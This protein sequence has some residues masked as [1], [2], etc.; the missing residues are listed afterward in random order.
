MGRAHSQAR[1][2]DRQGDEAGRH[3]CCQGERVPVQEQWLVPDP[4]KRGRI[5]KAWLKHMHGLGY[6][7]EGKVL[8][9]ADYGIPTIWKRYFGIAQADGRP[10][11]WPERTHAPRHL[12]KQLG[13]KPW[14]G[15]HTIIDWSLP[16]KSIF[17]RRKPLADATLRRTAK[18][19]MRYVVNAAR[20][21][22]VPITH[23]GA[24]RV[25]SLDEPL[26]TLTTA[27]RGELSV[28]APSLQAYYGGEQGLRRG[29]DPQ[30]PL[31]TFVTEPR[32]AL[33]TAHLQRDFGNSIGANLDEPAPT[34][35]PGGGG[36]SA[37]VAAF[38]AQHNSGEPGRPADL[39]LSTIVS[40]GSTQGVVTASMMALR[41]TNRHGRDIQEPVA[42]VTAGG[43]HAGVMAADLG[44]DAN[45][46]AHLILGFLQ[47]Y[48]SNGKQD[49]DIAAPLGALTQKARHGLVTATVGR[50]TF[51]INDIGMRMLE[52]EEGAAAHGF[53]RGSLP[54]K[55][56]IDGVERKLTKTEKYHLVGNSVP[57][58]MIRLL[59]ACN[60]RQE[61]AEAAE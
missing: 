56:T 11:V 48:Y 12:A 31:Q 38:M 15:A 35:T 4:K 37:L 45:D 24:D 25:H 53:A 52:P 39:P 8:V 22:I 36:K 6:S 3:R 41:G 9:C 7:F 14:V 5:W 61:F 30:E 21:F 20:P 40:K 29:G 27:H 44:E 42:T 49:D 2:C 19:V 26:R 57:P 34:V 16:V 50:E 54:D 51:V 55:I 59:A 60:V 23:T 1:S 46:N 17:D 43:C 18:G 58:E 32:H 47:H 10:I 13:L 28:V 33:V